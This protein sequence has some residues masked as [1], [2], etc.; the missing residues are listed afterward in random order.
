MYSEE[1]IAMIKTEKGYDINID[2]NELGES[3]KS[4][5][6]EL[7]TKSESLIEQIKKSQKE[8]ILSFN[9]NKAN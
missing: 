9:A 6:N 5:I 2:E 4:R 7:K 1:K 3:L 8:Y